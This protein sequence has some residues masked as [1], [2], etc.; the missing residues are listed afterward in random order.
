VG[1]AILDEGAKFG[2]ET[3]FSRENVAVCGGAIFTRISLTNTLI[4][5]VLCQRGSEK[6]PICRSGQN[7][8]VER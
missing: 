7:Y 4:C 2:V 5:G 3:A 1:I 6:P 8:L